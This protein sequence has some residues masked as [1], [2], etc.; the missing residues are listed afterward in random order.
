MAM[1]V[2]LPDDLDNQL[3]QIARERHVSKHAVILEATAR[4][5]ASEAKTAKVVSAVDDITERYAEA[6]DRLRDA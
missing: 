2:R 3:E 6:L 5:V 4:F 1:T